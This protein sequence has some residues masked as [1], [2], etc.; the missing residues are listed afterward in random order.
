MKHKHIFRLS[1]FAL[2]LTGCGKDTTE[3]SEAPKTPEGG[4][5]A[6]VYRLSIG[7]DGQSLHHGT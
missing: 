5:D 6:I 7:N 1:L 2:L 3:L 4:G